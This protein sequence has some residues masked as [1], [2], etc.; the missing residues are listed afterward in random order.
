MAPIFA[1]EFAKSSGRSAGRCHLL[2]APAT[3]PDATSSCSHGSSESSGNRLSMNR[4]RRRLQGQARG[5][6]WRLPR[7]VASTR[8][9]PKRHEKEHQQASCHQQDV[10][11]D[12]VSGEAIISVTRLTSSPD[13][14]SRVTSCWWHRRCWCSFSWSFGLWRVLATKR[15]R[16]PQACLAPGLKASARAVIDQPGTARFAGSV[17]NRT[18]SHRGP[19]GAE[20]TMTSSGDRPELLANSRRRLGPL[21]HQGAQHN[22]G[23][24]YPLVALIHTINFSY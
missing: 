7:L 22:W 17:A 21:S 2:H 4:S 16:A 20:S 10:T 3:V 18:G 11:L 14:P 1:A 23:N 13:T 9:K 24:F 6:L 19:C 15:G 5:M 8:H 12:G